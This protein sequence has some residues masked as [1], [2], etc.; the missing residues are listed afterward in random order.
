MRNSIAI[1][2][3]GSNSIRL[4]I[5]AVNDLDG[6]SIHEQASE[7][8]RLSEGL[9]SDLILKEAPIQ[10][11]IRALAYFKKLIEVNSVQSVYALATAA[12]RMAVNQSEFLD[13]VKSETGFDFMVLSGDQEAYY[14]YLGVVNSMELRDALIVDIGGGSTELIW[15]KDRKLERAVS[16][17][18]GSVTLSERF[19][20]IK[21]RKKRVEAAETHIKSIYKEISWLK[22]LKDSPIIGLGGV[23]RTLGK[24]D[25]AR[26]GY[27]LENLHNYRLHESEVAEICAQIFDSPQKDLENIQGI[28]KRRADIIALGILPFKCLFERIDAPEIR[29][30]GNGLRDGFFYEKHFESLSLPIVVG[31][32]LSQSTLNMMRRFNV[33]EKHAN[34]V[35]KLTLKVFD[36]LTGHFDYEAGDRKL[37]KTA[38]LLHDIGMHIEYYDHHIHGYYLIM[39]GRLEGLTNAE[40]IKVAFLVGNHRASGIK[41]QLEDY[42]GIV[43]KE[44]IQRLW[45]LAILIMLCEQFDRAENGSVDDLDVTVEK[46]AIEI[47]LIGSDSYDLEITSAS[48]FLDRFEKI[49]K[50]KLVMGD[51]A[52]LTPS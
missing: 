27:P 22:H 3:L 25:R 42:I 52:D 2:D 4:N 11:T 10:R 14:D 6:Y 33:H 44:E 21:S 38:A 13:R 51:G 1:I 16:L 34:H 18:L 35:M 49:Y 50:R 30:S 5:Y 20:D 47:R 45:K 31:D 36:A 23:I 41:K 24:V 40:R 28:S 39:N 17:P 7:M 12:V 32:V 15:M 48:Q 46:N 26:N 9:G 19:G 8:V 29:I 43:S 37:L